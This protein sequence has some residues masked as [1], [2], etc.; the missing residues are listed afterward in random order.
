MSILATLV[1]V[2]LLLTFFSF[3]TLH[4]RIREE[5]LDRCEDIMEQIARAISSEID[6]N[7]ET[8]DLLAS[9]FEFRYDSTDDVMDYFSQSREYL[10]I[11]GGFVVLVDDNGHGYTSLQ[12]VID[13]NL[14]DSQDAGTEQLYI[15]KLATDT[16]EHYL[17]SVKE[18]TEPVAARYQ[19]GTVKIKQVAVARSMDK[20]IAGIRNSMDIANDMYIIRAGQL[21]MSDEGAKIG[22][23]GREILMNPSYMNILDEDDAL[24][25][26]S[27]ISNTKSFAADFSYNGKNCIVSAAYLN[28]RGLWC[29]TLLNS[30]SIGINVN[31]AFVNVAVL[32]ITVTVLTIA[33]ASIV[34]A[35]LMRKRTDREFLAKTEEAR[36]SD[37]IFKT[38]ADKF[39]FVC[40]INDKSDSID[41]FH[42]A[43]IF[44]IFNAYVGD[45]GKKIKPLDF[46]EC[47]RTIIPED[48]FNDFIRAVDRNTLVESIADGK[49]V[50]RDFRFSKDG[51]ENWYRLIFNYDRSSE[52]VVLGICNVQAEYD[53]RE[54]AEA[55]KRERQR[56]LA[57]LA[58]NFEVVYDVDVDSGQYTIAA[59]SEKQTNNVFNRFLDP[60]NFFDLNLQVIK[61]ELYEEDREKLVGALTRRYIKEALSENDTFNTEYRVLSSDSLVWY[62]MKVI[63]NGEW[64][65]EHRILVGI[66]NND[67]IKRRERDYELKLQEAL[68]LAQSANRAKTLFLNNMSHDIRTP[69]NAIIGFTGLAKKHLD[70]T[71]QVEDYLTKTGVAS[72]HLLSLINDVLD[73]SRIEAGKI[74]LNEKPENLSEILH[75]LRDLVQADVKKK[76]LKLNLDAVDVTNEDVL[77]DRLRLNQILLNLVSNSIKYTPDGGNVSI[78]LTQRP[79]VTAGYSS[80]EFRVSD[81]GIGMSEEFVETIF[82]PFSRENTATVSGIQG[83]GLGMAITKNMADMMGGDVTVSSVKGEGTEFVF[84]VEF[85]NTAGESTEKAEFDSMRVLVVDSNIDSCTNVAGMLKSMGMRAEVC[86]HGKEALAKCEEAKNANDLYS[87]VFYD[88]DDQEEKTDKCIADMAEVLGNTAAVVRVSSYDPED[89]G[90]ETFDERKPLFRSDLERIIRRFNTNEPAK[91]PEKKTDEDFKGRKVLIVE[92]NELNREIACDLLSDHEFIVDTAEDGTVAVAKM[93]FA[94]P[95]DYDIILMDIQMPKMDGY[96]ATR[97]IRALEDKK[98]ADI[99]IVAMTAN[100]FVEDRQAALEA[101]MNDHIAK[102]VNIP[103]FE[104][105]LRKYLV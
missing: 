34:F 1:V 3:K 51:I 104:E 40:Y 96:E 20:I 54:A 43:G 10:R 47:M 66:Y 23:S 48:K 78:R 99:P 68:K 71:E 45:N 85:K 57:S 7:S 82:E 27:C 39:S 18:L 5:R 103:V 46:D 16:D 59:E 15:T 56:I 67:E 36:K 55:S 77:C 86:L 69:M 58:E 61:N 62:K 8:A 92:D 81:T 21:V 80:Y 6:S 49:R 35:G 24:R 29:V 2:A 74:S 70:N 97:R 19:N 87:L 41:I 53:E 30:E 83:T 38:L 14:Y 31:R 11:D 28:R 84:S 94:K 105:I 12:T 98:L 102:P 13:W 88:V 79:N 89:R 25:L 17:V 22:I 73:M 26:S 65:T 9:V 91:V 100:A 95:G 52:N 76:N 44:E 42:A 37:E 60:E 63:R 75:A 101:G 64:K 90:R 32:I 50:T 4:G 93:Q 33:M 72:E